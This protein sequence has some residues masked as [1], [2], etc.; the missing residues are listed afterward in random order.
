MDLYVLALATE[1]GQPHAW[2]EENVPRQWMTTGVWTFEE[3]PVAFPPTIPCL[4][5]ALARERLHLADC[6]DKPF[7]QW[8]ISEHK[9]DRL[10]LR[11][12]RKIAF[13]QASLPCGGVFPWERVQ[14]RVADGIADVAAAFVMGPHEVRGDL[15]VVG[16]EDALTLFN[17]R[18]RGLVEWMGMVDE[19]GE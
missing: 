6:E 4:V 5:P 16:P 10:E 9:V 14:F 2:L 12:W 13:T 15:I 18:P 19:D 1:P 7:G 11:H 8:I 3:P 17:L